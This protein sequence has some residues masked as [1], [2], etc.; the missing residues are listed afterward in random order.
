M[1]VWQKTK[2]EWISTFC[3]YL[4]TNDDVEVVEGHDI[5]KLKTFIRNW[6]DDNLNSSVPYDAPISIQYY[7]ET[8]RPVEVRMA[9]ESNR[10]R[11]DGARLQWLFMFFFGEPNFWMKVA[12]SPTPVAAKNYE[13]LHLVSAG[14]ARP[15]DSSPGG[16]VPV[17]DM[18]M[19]DGASSCLNDAT[20]GFNFY[21][22]TAWI[23]L[24]SLIS[25]GYGDEPVLTSQHVSHAAKDAAR[26][27]RQMIESRSWGKEK[28]RY[29]VDEKFTVEQFQ[30]VFSVLGGAAATKARAEKYT[31]EEWSELCRK[32]GKASVEA[33]AEKYTTEERFELCRKAG[34]ARAEKYTTEERSKQIQKGMK[35]RK[36]KYTP[37]E[38]SKLYQKEG[39]LH[40]DECM[41]L[42]P[43]KIPAICFQCG[44]T[45]K[46]IYSY[47]ESSN[48]P[49]LVLPPCRIVTDSKKC[50]NSGLAPNVRYDSKMLSAARVDNIKFQLERS[51][52]MCYRRGDSN[53]PP[54]YDS[55][56]KRAQAQQEM[57]R[58]CKLVDDDEWKNHP[59]LVPEKKVP[60]RCDSC[61]NVTNKKPSTVQGRT[62][63]PCIPGKR[64][65]RFTRVDE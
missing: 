46:S 34:K 58:V 9:E 6:L 29:D 33:R 49:I 24:C 53:I 37:E 22:E 60:Y 35:A 10:M 52:P 28:S 7:G 15:E 11:R 64:H 54:K 30:R 4:A 23:E 48:G 21:D 32:A 57:A 36:E 65:K 44:N 3:S 43:T 50:S 41:K 14:G 16:F 47:F 1:R 2:S 19:Y 56:K 39:S 31:T 8:T 20:G 61:G 59:P 42:L 51:P 17:A 38:F 12:E 5:E 62:S 55:A 27:M 40:Q 45:E 63:C 13:A 18:R 26:G 25:L